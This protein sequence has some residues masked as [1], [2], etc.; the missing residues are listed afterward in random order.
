MT[1]YHTDARRAI[2]EACS[3]APCCIAYNNGKG[4]YVYNPVDGCSDEPE[5]FI[6]RRG[7]FIP[8]SDTGS[9][10]LASALGTSTKPLPAIS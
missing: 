2:N 5:L 8:L 7:F 9:E 1:R 3:A 6:P 10:V 4:W